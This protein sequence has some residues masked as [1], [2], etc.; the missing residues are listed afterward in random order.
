MCRMMHPDE[1]R[2]CCEDPKFCLVCGV[3]RSDV[4]VTE[5]VCEECAR[6]D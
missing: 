6:G 4:K 2:E 3:N 1:E 5:H